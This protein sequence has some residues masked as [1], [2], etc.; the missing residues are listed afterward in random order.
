MFQ[1][2][3][4]LNGYSCK[5][6]GFCLLYKNPRFYTWYFGLSLCEL[7]WSSDLKKHGHTKLACPCQTCWDTPALGKQYFFTF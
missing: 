6:F 2:E 7:L 4:I 5:T 1:R 3:I